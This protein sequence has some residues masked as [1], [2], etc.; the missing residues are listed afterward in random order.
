MLLEHQNH[1]C[2]AGTRQLTTYL[3]FE[4]VTIEAKRESSKAGA[5]PSWGALWV[6]PHIKLDPPRSY[7]L[8]PR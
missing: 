6:T 3:S 1:R 4:S 8:R 2:P 5:L 7:T